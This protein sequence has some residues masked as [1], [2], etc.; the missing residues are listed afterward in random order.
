MYFT[1]S[2]SI[3]FL[4]FIDLNLLRFIFLLILLTFWPLW[5]LSHWPLS[6][7]T[8]HERTQMEY[9]VDL[10]HFSHSNIQYI[11]VLFFTS[12]S[13]I[14]YSTVL[15]STLTSKLLQVS[16]SLANANMI[17]F[18]D[19]PYASLIFDT[20]KP[21]AYYSVSS[22]VSYH[23]VSAM[24]LMYKFC[25]YESEEFNYRPICDP[26]GFKRLFNPILLRPQMCS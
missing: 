8:S 24:K 6:Y 23:S 17:T 12:P 25:S 20:L 15:Y 9:M 22:L 14:R 16:G 7:K 5:P 3:C 13:D 21:Q 19:L 1:F 2:E 11:T 18:N 4:R 26:L 10:F